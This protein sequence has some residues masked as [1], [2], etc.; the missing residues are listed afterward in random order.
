MPTGDYRTDLASRGMCALRLQLFAVSVPRTLCP[1]AHQFWDQWAVLQTVEDIVG[2]LF[3]APL[4]YPF[5]P[6]RIKHNQHH[7]FTNKLVDDTAWHPVMKEEAEELSGSAAGP[8][9]PCFRISDHSC[10]T[11]TCCGLRC[12]LNRP[13]LRFCPH[14]L[15]QHDINIHAGGSLSDGNKSLNTCLVR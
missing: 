6:W 1:S 3:F 12:T 4:L 5:E 8:S 11:Q 7:A 10:L 2:N 14:R 9:H 15:A 13:S